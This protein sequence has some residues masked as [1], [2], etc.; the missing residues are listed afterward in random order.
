[1][2]KIAGHT[3]GT[4]GMSPLDAMRLFKAAG[5]DAAE[6]IWQNDYA[7]AIPEQDSAA[8]VRDIRTLSQDLDFPIVCLTPYMTEINNPDDAGRERD[9]DRFR[10]CIQ[11]AASLDCHRI[12]VYGGRWLPGDDQWDAKWARLV[13]SLQTLGAEAQAAGVILCVEDHFNTMT[14]RAAQAASLMQ[15]VNHP[16]V[17]ILYDQC[18]L[19]FTHSEPYPE[20][21]ALQRPWIRHVHVKDIEFIDPDRPFTSSSVATVEPEA[22]TVR[23]RVVGDGILDW[24]AILADLHAGGYNGYLSLEYEYRWNP[25]DLPPPAEG[26]RRGAE[27]LRRALA[28]LNR[29]KDQV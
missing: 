24:P 11:V 10:R 14:V 5:L 7:A 15:A 17:G 23:S 26:F 8:L 19:V 16:G 1:M 25:Q 6:L 9:L 18:N 22:R 3:M 21:L 29:E 12:R 27:T 4:P 20:A 2:I 13:D 28:Q